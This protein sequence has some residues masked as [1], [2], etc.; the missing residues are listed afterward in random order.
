VARRR[1]PGR[2]RKQNA[3]PL[4]RIS[5]MLPSTGILG[6]LPEG[7][8][9][10]T[11]CSRSRAPIIGVPSSTPLKSATCSGA[12]SIR[13][14]PR[15]KV[16]RTKATTRRGQQERGVPGGPQLLHDL[17]WASSECLGST[18]QAG[19]PGGLLGKGSNAILPRLVR[20]T[21]YLRLRRPPR[22][23]TEPRKI[24]ACHRP[25]HRQR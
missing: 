10:S 24:P 19:T 8:T 17:R 1:R 3:T 18:P 5:S 23:H 6:N 20:Q 2:R 11:R 13:S 4:T 7:P 25:C 22:L 14:G 12:T 21:Y 15:Q 16:A 9:C